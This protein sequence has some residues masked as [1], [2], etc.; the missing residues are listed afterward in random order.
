M[1]KDI[2]INNDD[3][4]FNFRVAIDNEVNHLTV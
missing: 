2:V 4:I 1:N 3:F